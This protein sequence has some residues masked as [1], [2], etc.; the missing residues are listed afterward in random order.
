MVIP[1]SLQLT[2]EGHELIVMTKRLL[3]RKV[4]Y[5]KAVP[6]TKAEPLQLSYLPAG[7]WVQVSADVFSPVPGIRDYAIE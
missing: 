4:W 2:H 3:P 5:P 6:P 1:P 7:P